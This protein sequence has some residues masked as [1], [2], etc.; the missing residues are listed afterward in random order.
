[1]LFYLILEF[2]VHF[3]ALPIVEKKVVL[4]FWDI[5]NYAY[6]TPKHKSKYYAPKSKRKILVQFEIIN[7]KLHNQMLNYILNTL[8]QIN[9]PQKNKN[10]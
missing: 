3:D 10:D 6:Q 4:F 2:Y 9:R 5:L 7:N 8:N 1:M